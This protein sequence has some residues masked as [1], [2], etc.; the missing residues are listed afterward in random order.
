MMGRSLNHCNKME[1]E[2]GRGFL[3]Q[4]AAKLKLLIV[5]MEKML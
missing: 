3:K 4:L 1:A 5:Y 2:P